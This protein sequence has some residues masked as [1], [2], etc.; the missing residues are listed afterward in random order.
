LLAAAAAFVRVATKAR[1]TRIDC[2][3]FAKRLIRKSCP[4]CGEIQSLI[5]RKSD[6]AFDCNP[7][8]NKYSA[9]LLNSVK[10]VRWQWY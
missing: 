1:L 4:V 7:V 5:Y 9:A 6:H 2:E 8:D 3:T 10:K